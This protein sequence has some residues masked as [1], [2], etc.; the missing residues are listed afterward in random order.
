MA[1][2]KTS[3]TGTLLIDVVVAATEIHTFARDHGTSS[4]IGATAHALV[5]AKN[6]LLAY[7]TDLETRITELQSPVDIPL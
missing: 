4:E 7:I 3:L 6:I 1:L 5:D 2:P